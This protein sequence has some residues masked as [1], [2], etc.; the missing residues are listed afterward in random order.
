MNKTICKIAISCLMICVVYFFFDSFEVLASGGEDMFS[1]ANSQVGQKERS[2]GS[3]DIIYNDWYYGYRVSNNEN[4]FY[5]WCAV[6]V[7]WCAEQTGDLNVTIPRTCN[8]TQMKDGIVTRG[9]QPHLK[10]SGYQPVRGDIIF[11]GDNASQHVG[12]VDYSTSDRVYY[13]DGNNTSTNPHGVHYS[14]CSLSYSSLWGFVSP[15]YN[16]NTLEVDSTW[17]VPTTVTASKKISTYDAYGNMESNHYIDPGDS[18]YIQEVYTNGFVKVQYP[19]SGGTR[20][21]YAKRVDFTLEKKKNPPTG[22]GI[23]AQDEIY[24]CEPITVTV[25]PFDSDIT[26]YT[27]YFVSPNGDVYTHDIGTE[28]SITGFAEILGTWK[29]YAKIGNSDGEY[30][31]STTNGC[32]SFQVKK[33]DFGNK[34]NLGSDFIAYIK[35]D[36]SNNV[37]TNHNDNVTCDT[38][39][40][41]ISQQWKFTRKSDGS[42]EIESLSG[43]GKCLDAYSGKGRR[44]DNV[45][46]YK[47]E[48]ETLQSWNIYDAGN[49]YYYL[50]PSC[51]NSA[52]LD[53]TGASLESGTNMQIWTF[54][55]CNAQRFVIEKID[56]SCN[57]NFNTYTDVTPA[58]WCEDG[59]IETKCSN[60]KEVIGTEVIPNYDS[61][62][63]ADGIYSYEYSGKPYYPNVVVRDRNGNIISSDN[64]QVIYDGMKDLGASI[65]TVR[66]CNK[67]TGTGYEAFEINP[68]T[69]TIA[70]IK[71]T[72][73][74]INI[75]W[76]R[77]DEATSYSVYRIDKNGV[78]QCIAN[79]KDSTIVS[80]TDTTAKSDGT[81]YSY[82]VEA[83]DNDAMV[84]SDYSNEVSYSFVKPTKIAS[85][86][87]RA[88]GT[89]GVTWNKSIGVTG[90]KIK[91][92]DGVTTRNYTIKNPEQISHIIRS[93]ESGK[94]YTFYIISYVRINDVNYYSAWSGPIEHY[95]V[96]PTSISSIQNLGER[97][98]YVKWNLANN[99]SGY[100]LMIKDVTGTKNVTITSA[101]RN[102][103]KL[104]NIE[105]GLKEKIYIRTYFKAGDKI[106]WSAWSEAK[107]HYYLET[108]AIQ[109]AK[110]GRVGRVT[111]FWETTSRVTG[112]EIRAVSSSST[113][114]FMAPSR[115]NQ[116]QSGLQSGK[117]YKFYIRSYC[118]IG[119]KTYYSAWSS[120]K[121]T[122]VM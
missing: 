119:G 81:I 116:T 97:Q 87:N 11:F 104:S 122:I 7:S 101:T 43:N 93:F 70:G 102:N 61:V 35:N 20:W 106:Y 85:I 63:I 86:I 98:V 29:V 37:L 88:D 82:V 2:S 28:N 110:S 36:T 83:R 80:Y 78:M 46:V 21:A 121:G 55:Q 84:K 24:D 14:S 1:V 47:G 38:L 68:R 4:G 41:D 26:N 54:N 67:Y 76:N 6:F 52:V 51:S 12:I 64:Y 57:H 45:Q 31:G 112:Y 89:V 71:N 74:G 30:C 108:P 59:V 56:T 77:I 49:G 120:G 105:E 25:N 113:L 23:T 96:S 16:V 19:V 40:E 9:G 95:Y 5:P 100:R 79:I 33:P 117:Y 27:L 107:I 10:G 115:N 39:T 42:Y 99:V 50:N 65:I 32:V 72:S 13:V 60:C 109:S 69:P 18:C 15:A 73:S 94:R 44:A 103:W 8:T 3:D 118:T 34:I 91:I 66:F 17:N 111:L 92:G 114:M 75:T 58:T 53:V 90:Y 22:Y 48:G 62:K